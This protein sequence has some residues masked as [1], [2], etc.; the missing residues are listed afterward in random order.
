MSHILRD[1]TGT[2]LQAK[3]DDTNRLRTRTISEPRSVEALDN[4]EQ[5]I[6]H[7]A[8]MNITDAS[9]TAIGYIENTGARDIIIKAIEV[10]TER[11]NEDT[12]TVNPNQAGVIM[13]YNG[14][15]GPSFSQQWFT[16]NA[17]FGSPV[18][19]SVSALTAPFGS[20]GATGQTFT[21][22]GTLVVHGIFQCGQPYLPPLDE[23][24]LRPGNRMGY[25]FSP[26]P[27]NTDMDIHLNVICYLK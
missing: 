15:S 24:K 20:G 22:N 4:G 25:R 6:L 2:K 17:D 7:S 13:I 12:G 23:I 9:T 16:N 3:V 1:G 21:S 26:P 18:V 5:F 14:S 8:V 27:N 11:S 19:L 10:T